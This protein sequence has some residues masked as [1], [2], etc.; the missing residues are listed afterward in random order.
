MTYSVDDQIEQAAAE[1]REQGRRIMDFQAEL[2][3]RSTTVESKD[4]MVSATVNGSGRLTGLSIKGNRYRMMPPAELANLVLETVNAALDKASAETM[5]AAKALMPG[6]F[7]GDGMD[8]DG[9]LDLEQLMKTAMEKINDPAL[10][11]LDT[12]GGGI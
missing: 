4:R 10:R 1:L 3:R 9:N 5:A 8:A 2:D 6:S 11:W 12:P 7:G